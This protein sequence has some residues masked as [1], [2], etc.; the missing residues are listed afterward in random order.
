MLHLRIFNLQYLISCR[1]HLICSTSCPASLTSYVVPH[2]LPPH[3]ICSTSCPAYLTSSTVP[4][5]LPS[6]PYL[7]CLMSWQTHAGRPHAKLS[8]V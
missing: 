6:S 4:H 8:C 3:L 5:A 7:Q 1:S 2:A